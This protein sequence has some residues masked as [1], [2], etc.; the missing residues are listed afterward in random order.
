MNSRFIK[1]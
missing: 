1:Y